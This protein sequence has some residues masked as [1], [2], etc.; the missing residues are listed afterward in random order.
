MAQD[1]KQVPILYRTPVPILDTK[2][3]L[4]HLKNRQYFFSTMNPKYFTMQ[5]LSIISMKTTPK[6]GVKFS[7]KA[8]FSTECF[9]I[10]L[11]GY[12]I[13][14]RAIKKITSTSNR[15][16]IC[17]NVPEYDEIMKFVPFFR[18]AV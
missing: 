4:P 17:E 6:M 1:A 9:K 16:K 13:V 14:G 18:S 5:I 3:W 8:A 2:I 12:P 11:P 10:L 15:L 7:L